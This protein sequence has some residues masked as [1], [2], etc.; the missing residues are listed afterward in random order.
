MGN[1]KKHLARRV[2]CDPIVSSA[3][4]SNALATPDDTNNADNTNI[5]DDTNRTDDKNDAPVPQNLSGETSRWKKLDG[6]WC[7]V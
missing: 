2:I 6:R 4:P 3:D 5:A 7:L 1:M